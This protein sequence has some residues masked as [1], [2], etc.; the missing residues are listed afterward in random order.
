MVKKSSFLKNLIK[1]VRLRIKDLLTNKKDEFKISWFDE[2]YL[3]HLPANKIH[4]YKL[5]GREFSFRG[6]PD[7]LNGLQEIFVNKIYYQSLPDNAY[8]IDCGAHIGMSMI[9]FKMICPS[10][11]ILC[12]E[13]DKM[14]FELLQ[15]NIKTYKTEKVTAYNMAVWTKDSFLNFEMDGNM[16]SRIL[17]NQSSGSKVKACRLAD[18]LTE[19][20]DLL[21]MDIEGAEY[22]VLRDIY[23]KLNNVVRMFIEYHGSFNQNKELIEILQIINDSGFHFYIKEAGHVYPHPFTGIRGNSIYDLQLNIF[24]MRD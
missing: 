21:K 12:F 6:G 13:P 3:K 22:E 1:G 20:V 5:L 11:R 24:C 4:F 14:N 8:V 18:F 16:S 7:F 19:K 10:A 23:P 2:K 9:Y 17:E 15:T